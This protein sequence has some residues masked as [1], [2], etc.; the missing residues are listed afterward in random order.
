MLLLH[1]VQHLRRKYNLDTYQ[2]QPLSVLRKSGGDANNNYRI[3]EEENVIPYG[4]SGEY[5]PP[6]T[7][8]VSAQSVVQNA[9]LAQPRKRVR[10]KYKL[11][12]FPLQEHIPGTMGIPPPEILWE[13][14]NQQKIFSNKSGRGKKA[15]ES[16]KD[17]LRRRI[18]EIYL[19]NYVKNNSTTR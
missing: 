14:K 5:F 15:K 3:K 11:V 18:L 17:K 13:M 7:K 12:E 16:K 1:Y 9:V 6:N 10:G 4:Y 2:H 8:I 19:P